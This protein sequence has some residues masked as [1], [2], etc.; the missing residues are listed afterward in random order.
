MW[1][2]GAAAPSEQGGLCLQRHSCARGSAAVV[3]A[4]VLPAHLTESEVGARQ[5]APEVPVLNYTWGNVVQDLGGVPGGVPSSLRMA[6]ASA[7]GMYGESRGSHPPPQSW[8]DNH[9]TVTVRNMLM[10]VG[11]NEPSKH[12]PESRV[13]LRKALQRNN[14]L[15]NDRFL[16]SFSELPAGRQGLEATA[17]PGGA[18]MQP[19]LS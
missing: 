17:G 18:D 14:S 5:G 9:L 11:R 10:G 8:R 19:V 1:S 6:I 13:N 15:V 2:R 7:S 12:L 16:S 3:V 4:A